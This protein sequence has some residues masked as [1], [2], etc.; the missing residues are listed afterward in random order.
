[1]SQETGQNAQE[2]SEQSESITTPSDLSTTKA[3]VQ[4]KHL[5]P[6]IKG[7]W[8]I[9]PFKKEPWMEGLV[10]PEFLLIRIA[11]MTSLHSQRHQMAIN[12]KS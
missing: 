5:D 2:K 1:M 7:V 9:I 3:K 4:F 6:R 11:K 12:A 8:D 10:I